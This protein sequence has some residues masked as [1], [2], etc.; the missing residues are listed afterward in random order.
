MRNHNNI[1]VLLSAIFLFL[2]SFS[3]SIAS[4]TGIDVGLKVGSCNNNGICERDTEDIFYC[5]ADCTPVNTTGSEV[6]GGVEENFF[7]NLTVEVSYNSVN[8]KWQSTV[9]TTSNINWGTNP[10]YKDGV[11]RNANFILDHNVRIDNLKDGTLYYFNIQ[12]EDLLGKNKSI[13]NQIFRTLFLPDTTPPGNVTNIK[14][15][16]GISGITISWN[17]PSDE[18]FDYIR[19]MRNSTKNTSPY[20]GKLVYEGKGNYFTDSKV[21]EGIRYFYSLFSRDRSGNYSSGL[22]VEVTHSLSGNNIII[23][24]ST[25]I[26]KLEKEQPEIDKVTTSTQEER[27]ESTFWYILWF[28]MFLLLLLLILY[29]ILRKKFKKKE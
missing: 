15:L 25:Q 17:N 27:K 23:L 2:G 10:D 21:K 28:N 3:F 4:S 20:N 5:P 14:I 24:P 19:V 9:P 12:A 8:I 22:F 1:K 6:I 7:K 29:L 26:E 18:D 11:L 16:S 13:E